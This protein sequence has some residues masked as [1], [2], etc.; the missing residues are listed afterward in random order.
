MT[1]SGTDVSHFGGLGFKQKSVIEFTNA[2]KIHFLERFLAPD[3]DPSCN[4]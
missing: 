4:L 3:A 2:A 1:L